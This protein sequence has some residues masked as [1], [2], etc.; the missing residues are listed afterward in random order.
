M[1]NPSSKYVTFSIIRHYN[2]P[3]IAEYRGLTVR[4][5]EKIFVPEL[6]QFVV[7]ASYHDHFIFEVPPHIKDSSF[8]CTCGSVAVIPGYG[9][10]KDL[11]SPTQS[12]L[13]L[14]CL[15]DTSYGHH[16]TGGSRWI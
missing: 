6:R 15:I 8:R 1:N 7:C 11:A 9:A 10:Y 14:V 2:S 13:M 4:R 12:G 5:Q 3:N 16:A